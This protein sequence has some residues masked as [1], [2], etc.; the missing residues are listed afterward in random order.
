MTVKDFIETLDLIEFK[1]PVHYYI[2]NK[3][4]QKFRLYSNLNLIDAVNVTA[5][6]DTLTSDNVEVELPYEPSEED[7]TFIQLLDF[8]I[9]SGCTCVHLNINIKEK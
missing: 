9:P 4:E 1:I 7:I 2:N 3:L 6:L 8:K 5:Y